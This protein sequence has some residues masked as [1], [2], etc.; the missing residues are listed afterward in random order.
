MGFHKNLSLRAR[1]FWLI[2]LALALMASSTG[3]L[4]SPAT[5]DDD[6]D[7]VK[8]PQPTDAYESLIEF[9]VPN[10]AAVEELVDLGADLAETVNDNEDGTA[11]VFAYV[12]PRSASTTSRWASSPER[13]WRTTPLTSSGCKSAT[14]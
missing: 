6:E 4:L 3:L 12:T 1:R 10:R 5:G 11:T 13:P 8:P 14:L 7:T 2:G 9:T